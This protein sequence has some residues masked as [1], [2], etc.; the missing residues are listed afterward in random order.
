MMERKIEI[1]ERIWIHVCK[2]QLQQINWQW[3][4][5]CA[6]IHTHKCKYTYSSMMKNRPKKTIFCLKISSYLIKL[7]HNICKC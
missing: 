5:Q 6:N 4:A 7:C 2:Y 3:Y 1:T